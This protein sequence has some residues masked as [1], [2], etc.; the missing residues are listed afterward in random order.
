M[1]ELVLFHVVKENGIMGI[2]M[3]ESYAIKLCLNYQDPAGF[4]FLVN[5]YRREAFFHARI[6]LGNQEDAADACQE[7]FT[8]AFMAIPKLTHLDAFYPWFYRILRNCCLNMIR[9]KKSALKYQTTQVREHDLNVNHPKPLAELEKQEDKALIQDV[10]QAL[11]PEFREI[12]VMKYLKGMR[13]E[14]IS[15]YLKIPR[16]TVMS[17]LYYA[18]KAFRE[19]YIHMEKAKEMPRAEVTP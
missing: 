6:L 14:E 18:R 17:R 19:K 9:K 16:G 13:Y 2:R 8:R 1:T 15:Q 3:D 10:L 4:E 7:S 11:N 5:K 12:L